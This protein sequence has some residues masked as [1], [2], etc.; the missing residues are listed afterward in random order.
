[1]TK[2]FNFSSLKLKKERILFFLVSITA[3]VCEEI[4]FRGLIVYYFSHL[5]FDLSLLTIGIIASVLFGLV[6]LY[7]GW[8]GVLRT[9]YIGGILFFLYVGTGTL[10][11]PIALHFLIDVQLVFLPRANNTV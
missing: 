2:T 5:P 1:M 4:I 11:V 8:K 10:W 6:H 9:A 3:G 7:Q